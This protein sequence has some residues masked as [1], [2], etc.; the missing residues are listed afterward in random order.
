MEK[1]EI[2][3]E[4]T[5]F[6][7]F[8]YRVGDIELQFGVGVVVVRVSSIELRVFGKKQFKFSGLSFSI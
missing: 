6:R 2:C 3:V 5:S 1:L 4:E 8:L 7:G